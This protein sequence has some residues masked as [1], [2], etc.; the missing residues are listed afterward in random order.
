[1]RPEPNW[2]SLAGLGSDPDVDSVQAQ[3]LSHTS[4]LSLLAAPYVPVTDERLPQDVAEATLTAL[5]EQ[6]ARVMVDLP[7]VLNETTAAILDMADVVGG[8]E[9]VTE[10]IPRALD[11][12]RRGPPA[13]Q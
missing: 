9:R 5:R 12:E 2:L 3:L 11:C 7:S 13:F 1:M 4:G 6:H 10:E 8:K